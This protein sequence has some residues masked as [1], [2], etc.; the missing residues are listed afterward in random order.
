MNGLS[1]LLPTLPFDSLQDVIG[2]DHITASL[3]QGKLRDW[4]FRVVRKVQR[5]M[6]PH[7][8]SVP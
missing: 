3:A 7:V 6:Y 2:N 8:D 1:H 4:L 5:G